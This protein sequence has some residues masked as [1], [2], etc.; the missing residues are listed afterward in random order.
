M[1]LRQMT[2]DS[3]LTYTPAL[4]LDGKL[5]AY[6]S[7]RGRGGNTDIWVQQVAGGQAIRL[8]RHEADDHQPAFSADGSVIAFRS[9]RDGGGLYI[10]STLGGDERLIAKAG[11]RPRFSAD[12]KWLAYHIGNSLGACKIYLMPAAGGQAK[13]LQTD[14]AWAAWPVWSPDGKRLLFQGSMSP[15]GGMSVKERDWWVVP[16]EGGSAVKTSMVDQLR[17][18]RFFLQPDYWLGDRVLFS[19]GPVLRHIQI[20]NQ[21]FQAAGNAQRLTGGTASEGNP[22]GAPTGDI[23]FT[24]GTLTSDL[25]SLSVDANQG[26][27]RGELQRLTE[28]A[29]DDSSPHLSKDGKKMVFASTRSGNRDL[30]IRDVM[31]GKDRPLAATPASETRGRISPDGSR[32]AFEV[33]DQ[34]G[35]SVHLIPSDGGASEKLCD[36]CTLMDFSADGRTVVYTTRA[37]FASIDLETRQKI[38]IIKHPKYRL[39]RAAFSPDNKWLAMHVPIE[40]GKR[41]PVVVTALRGGQAS[42][43]EKDWIVV[44]DHL[45]TDR[46]P[47]WSPDGNLLYF[48]SERDGFVCFYA[49]R[50]DPATKHPLAEV[51]NVYHFH[52]A[53]RSVGAQAGYF[54]PSLISGRLVFS[55]TETTG[56]IWM[57]KLPAR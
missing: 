47:W 41:Q 3:G 7:D 14:I 28:D 37:G 11:V 57:T 29:A 36:D 2:Y 10:I 51:F 30:W 46:H 22:V 21:T 33:R 53:R 26:K 25:W 45:G 18:R 42:G 9:E 19:D 23:A 48:V 1:E 4:S 32:V 49:R 24:S 12:G 43:E 50:L 39:H 40:A 27:V 13:E 8:T 6:A 16:I 5:L 31:S 38:D 56:N 20:S 44:S 54:G 15:T 35:S 55:M 34:T 17:N 52:G